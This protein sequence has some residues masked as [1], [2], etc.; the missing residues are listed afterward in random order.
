M[1]SRRDGSASA[2][3]QTVPLPDTLT[4]RWRVEVGEG[5]ATPLIVGDTVYVFSRVNDREV[6]S[7]LDAATGAERWRAGYAA[8]YK[9]SSPTAAHGSG[10]KAT[11]LYQNG[12]IVTLGVSGIVAGFDAVR[13]TLLWR[14]TNPTEVPFYSAASSPLGHEQLA[15]LHPGNYGP[16]TAFETASGK[17]SWTA[18]GGGAF[19]APATVTI[20]GVPQVVSVTQA[21]VIGVSPGNGRIL[22]EYPWTGGRSGGIMPIPHGDSLVVSATSAGIV[23]IAPR[24]RGDV[25]TV[26]KAWDTTAAEMYISHPVIVGDVLYGFSRRANGQL[27]ALDVRDGRVLWLGEPRFATNV[28]FAKAGDLLFVLKDEADLIVARASPSGFTPLR[29]YHVADSAT[30]AQPVISGRRLFIKDTTGVT[31]WTFD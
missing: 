13:G 29:N 9:P 23:S 17:V 18:G 4:R 27:F 10:P 5:Y 26:S 19:M 24:R 28:A 3:A 11:P 1:G 25:W 16:L 12:R 21:G 22:W 31:L 30:W 8:P 15:I 2:F 7:A 14:T 20:D 6:L